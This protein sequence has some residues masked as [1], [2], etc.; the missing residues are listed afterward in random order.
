MHGRA[1]VEWLEAQSRMSA[2]HNDQES[3]RQNLCRASGTDHS[4][5][6]LWPVD[7]RFVIPSSPGSSLTQPRA[8]R[9]EAR[10]VNQPAHFRPTEFS[11]VGIFTKQ[12]EALWARNAR[13]AA[14]PL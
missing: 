3:L 14:R 6:G 9:R 8:R 13:P 2:S 1:A 4:L 5:R 10:A 12:A 7:C 11:L